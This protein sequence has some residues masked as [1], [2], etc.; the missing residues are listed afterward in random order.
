MNY[1]VTWIEEGRSFE[2]SSSETVLDAAL[3]AGVP[4]P[5]ECRFGGCGTCRVKL[6][7]GRVQYDEQPMG[8]A[9]EEATAGYALACQARPT[10]DLRIST[11]R[12]LAS[13]VAPTRR[14][15]TV[16]ALELLAHDV[17]KLTLSINGAAPFDFRPGQYM[18]VLLGKAGARSFSM[19]SSPG[20]ATADFHIRCIQG[21]YFTGQLLADL[22][23]GDQLDVELPLG[24]FGYHEEDFRPLVMVATGT[25][26]APL[27]SMLEHML[28]DPGCPPVALFWGARTPAD[29]Y[30]H[31]ALTELATRYPD[32]T[33]TPVLSRADDA[34]DGS[35]GYVQQAVVAACPDL[36]EHALYLCGSPDMIADAK[37]VFVDHGASVRYFYS[38]GFS[39]H[40]AD[41]GVAQTSSAGL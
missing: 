35:R 40:H 15:A 14:R 38:D 5:S 10:A 33:Y 3:R 1:Q 13:P 20:A 11:D 22:R 28:P 26:I 18:R 31:D 8:L 27:K 19:A 23:A 2:A 17:V 39:F 7:E 16:E 30:L 24:G 36:S 21:G 32:F 34:W 12:P 9:P 6:V 25:G 41:A 4:L 37:R 29:L